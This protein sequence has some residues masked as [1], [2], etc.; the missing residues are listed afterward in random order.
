[1]LGI[2][3][4]GIPLIIAKKLTVPETINDWNLEHLKK[5]VENGPKKY[6]GANYVIR[7][8]GKKKKIT[9]ET[10][11]ALLKSAVNT[12]GTVISYNVGDILLIEFKYLSIARNQISTIATN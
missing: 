10:K 3:E 11:E 6:P 1:M 12:S 8:D 4:I 5:F 7:P 2:N 9:E